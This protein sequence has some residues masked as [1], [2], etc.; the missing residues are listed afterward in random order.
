MNQMNEVSEPADALGIL[1]V[2]DYEIDRYRWQ[3][4]E[5]MPPL[6]NLIEARAAVA[7][8]IDKANTAEE[9]IRNLVTAGAHPN[10]LMYADDLHAAVARAGGSK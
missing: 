7:E 1:A 8:L 3:F 4:N 10:W 2:M 9:T 6:T 5:V